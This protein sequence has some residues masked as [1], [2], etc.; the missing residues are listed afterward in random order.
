MT[1]G[2]PTMRVRIE[3]GPDG[4]PYVAQT[5]DLGVVTWYDED[6]YST[7]EELAS[8]PAE[9]HTADS[10]MD[11]FTKLS[12]YQKKLFGWAM[13]DVVKVYAKLAEADVKAGVY[14]KEEDK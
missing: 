1:E 7:F 9:E 14:R 5:E 3:T 6:G 10:L 4:K 8:Q 13:Q 12:Q 2:V 11:E